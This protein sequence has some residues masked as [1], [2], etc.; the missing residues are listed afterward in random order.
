MKLKVFK[1]L[2]GMSGTLEEQ[3]RRIAEAGVYDGIETSM[4][5]PENEAHFRAVLAAHG[6][7]YVPMIFS[8]GATVQEHIASFRAN[9]QRALTFAPSVINAHG[10]KDYWSPEDQALFAGEALRATQELAAPNGVLV[11]HETHRGRLMFTPANTA[12]LLRKYPELRLNADFSH[13]CC[14]C[15]SLLDDQKEVIDLAC[16]RAV[17]IH[18][19]IGHQEGPQ[20]SDP[21]APEFAD[22]AAHHF[23]WWDA[24]VAAQRAS[25]RSVMSFTPEFGPPTYM[26]S[27]PYTRQPLAD[28]WDI[29]LYMTS[30]FRRRFEAA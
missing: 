15:E 23:A 12:V 20:V 21:R 3:A 29:C 9:L 8:F 26:P 6:L 17:H 1:S 28:L 11:G 14:V 4:P 16:Q 5:A 24:I 2:W 13:W 22:A 10:G 7:D 30:E 25:G 18:G 19:R 27:L